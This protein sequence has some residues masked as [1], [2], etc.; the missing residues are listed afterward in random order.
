MH[1]IDTHTHIYDEAFAGEEDLAVARAVEAGISKMILPDID[2]QTREAMLALADRHEG[3]LFPCIGLHPTSVDAGWQNEMLQVENHLGRKIY[4]IGEI[5]MDCYWSKEFL[6]EQ[7]EV[8]RIQLETA[9]RMNLPAII[10]SRES[11]ELIIK[12]LKDCAHLG[13]RGVF[14]AFSG[15]VETFRELSRTGDWYIGIGGVLTYKKASI[16]ETVKQIPLERILL[17]T[18]SPYLTP[19]PFRGKR[20]E[21]SYIPH[22]AGRLAELCGT[23]LEEVAHT[24]TENA[25]KLFGI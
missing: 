24:T 1:F 11:T 20:N 22:I 25:Q 14:H 7:E 21:S 2:S 9:S 16:A 3:T 15:S 5:G 12:I 19:V 10:H 4:A 13:L 17:E 18:D 8:L 23:S 6:Q